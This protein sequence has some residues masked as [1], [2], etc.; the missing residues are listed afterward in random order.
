[1]T[2]GF[3]YLT[4]PCEEKKKKKNSTFSLLLV[5]LFPFGSRPPIAKY[6]HFVA[7]ILQTDD[8]SRRCL[9]LANTARHD[10]PNAQSQIFYLQCQGNKYTF[11][12]NILVRVMSRIG[13]INVFFSQ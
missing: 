12:L 9:C 3:C 13:G 5:G 2:V 6:V 1:M 11:E 8:Q 7:I 10:V 4:F